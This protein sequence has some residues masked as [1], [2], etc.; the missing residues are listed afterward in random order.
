VAIARA[1]I[2]DPALILADEP[3]GNLDAA[4]GAEVLQILQ[5]L[6]A[7]GRTIVLVTHDAAIAAAATRMIFLEDGRVIAAPRAPA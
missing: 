1:L 6:V 7:S 3:T 5:R 2:N 4:A